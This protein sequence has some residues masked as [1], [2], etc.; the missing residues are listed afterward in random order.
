[1]IR[2]HAIAPIMT[3]PR[4]KGEEWSE[5]AKTAML[6]LAREELF[7]VRK[8]LDDVRCIQKGKACEDEAIELYN[9]VFLYDLKKLPSDGRKNI[10][11]ITGEPDLV[12]TA[13][14]KGVDIKVAWSLLTFPLTEEQCDKKAMNGRLA[15]IW[16][17][18][19]C[20]SGRLLTVQLIRQ[21]KF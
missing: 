13:S 17:Y 11:I 7:G 8:S 4:T 14:K 10:G 9:S 6:D 21:K 12:A 2:C 18:S 19:I 20:P 1:M 5:T 16:L 3:N 15:G